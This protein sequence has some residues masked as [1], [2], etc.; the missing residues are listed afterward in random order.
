MLQLVIKP[1][2]STFLAT[3]LASLGAVVGSDVDVYASLNVAAMMLLLTWSTV[4]LAALPS[5]F[6]AEE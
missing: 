3:L 1:G 4:A 5:A 6:S 2:S